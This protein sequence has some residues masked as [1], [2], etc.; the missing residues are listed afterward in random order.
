MKSQVANNFGLATS[1]VSTLLEKQS[2]VRVA[3]ESSTF[4]VRRK[5]LHNVVYSAVEE[6][7]FTWLKQAR[8]M[9]VP[10]PGTILASKRACCKI[11]SSQF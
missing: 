7:L 11:G 5:R 8:S 4:K 10:V 9:N 2:K 6:A 1:M 3:Y